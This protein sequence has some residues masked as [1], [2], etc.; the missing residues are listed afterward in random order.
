MQITPHLRWRLSFSRITASLVRVGSCVP[1][2]R[3]RSSQPCHAGTAIVFS[4]T[5]V[6]S[7]GA[8]SGLGTGATITVPV[9]NFSSLLGL[10][11]QSPVVYA[12]EQ[13]GQPSQWWYCGGSANMNKF[14]TYTVPLSLSPS[15]WNS[16]SP[17]SYGGLPNCN[18]Q[19]VNVGKWLGR[20][21]QARRN[22]HPL[23]HLPNITI[24]SMAEPTTLALFQ[25]NWNCCP[26]AVGV[27]TCG[28]TISCEHITPRC[29][30]LLGAIHLAHPPRV[31]ARYR[32]GIVYNNE[33]DCLSTDT[34]F[35][36]GG[37]CIF[38]SPSLPRIFTHFCSFY[39][40]VS[41]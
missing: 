28:I 17:G 14:V 19:G 26:T 2:S 40:A 21:R 7:G 20:A 9:G 31:A 24:A 10:F 29:V 39:F 41:S 30:A 18:L 5:G 15:T 33:A 12:T 22:T 27:G 34:S 37:D 36:I 11:S 13:P 3:A 32:L 23:L 1:C 38:V 6:T 8:F 25:G 16:A 35:G 4:M